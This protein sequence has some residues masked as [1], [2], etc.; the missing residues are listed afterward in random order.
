[1]GFVCVFICAQLK[2]LALKQTDVTESLLSAL[3]WTNYT[4]TTIVTVKV[5]FFRLCFFINCHL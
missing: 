3:C 5:F 4:A 2:K 1:M